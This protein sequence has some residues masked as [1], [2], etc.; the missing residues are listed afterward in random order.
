MNLI[1]CGTVQRFWDK[2]KI[3][4]SCWEWQAWRRNG[5]G[6]FSCDG[7][8]VQAH[9]YAY[10]L[11]EDKIPDGLFIDHHCKNPKC[12]N[13]AHLE[14][15]TNAENIRRGN[16]PPVINSKKTHCPLGHPLL[17]NNIYLHP[18]TNT[19]ECKLCRNARN[20]SYYAKHSYKWKEVYHK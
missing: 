14:P 19:R 4:D 1:K 12:V 18:K 10:E 13:P 6:M 11:M 2:V 17:G 3:T 5:Y 7:K 16:S 15:V 8:D 9:R 20:K